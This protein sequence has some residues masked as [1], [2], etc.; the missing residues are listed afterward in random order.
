MLAIQR[1][2]GKLTIAS[3]PHRSRVAMLWAPYNHYISRTLPFEENGFS[4]TWM[5]N[6]SVIGGAP[7]DALT[8]LNSIRVRPTIIAPEDLLEGG[9][10]RQGFRAL[11]LPYNKGMSLS[12]ADAIREFVNEGGLVIADN[13]PATYTE[14]GRKLEKGRLAD[15]FP[16]TDRIHLERIG[17]GPRGLSSKRAQRLYRPARKGG[18]QRF[19]RRCPTPARSMPA[20]SHRS[21]CSTSDGRP[22]RDVFARVFHNGSTQLLGL[23]CSDTAANQESSRN[24][25]QA[26]VQAVCL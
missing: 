23:L 6:I 17:Q 8:L 2:I 25:S 4:G 15:L 5:S 11:V 1:G 12:E 22:R 19:G 13:D 16:V 3:E 20:S 21:N 26:F 18:L 9:L 7:A 10:A 14:H 24:H